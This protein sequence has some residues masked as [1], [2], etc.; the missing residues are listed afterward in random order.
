MAKSYS[1]LFTAALLDQSRKVLDDLRQMRASIEGTGVSFPKLDIPEDATL[2]LR[3]LMLM[4][5][6]SSLT[7]E[8]K[9]SFTETIKDLMKGTY[10]SY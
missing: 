6:P 4:H 5:V 10:T 9:A 2:K 1:V 3:Q 8:A 7:T